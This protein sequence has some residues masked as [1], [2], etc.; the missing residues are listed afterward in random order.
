MVFQLS[1]VS[2]RPADASADFEAY[3]KPGK[4]QRF[5]E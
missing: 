5:I 1:L 3:K 4:N 2:L